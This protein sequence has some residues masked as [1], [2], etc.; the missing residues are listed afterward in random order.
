LIAFSND[1][2]DAKQIQRITILHDEIAKS[3]KL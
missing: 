1:G 3:F 2:D